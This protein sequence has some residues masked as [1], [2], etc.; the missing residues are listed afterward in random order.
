MVGAEVSRWSVR[1]QDV[2]R[3]SPSLLIFLPNY[4]LVYSVSRCLFCQTQNPFRLEKRL[5]NQ[6]YSS[7]TKTFTN[8]CQTEGLLKRDES[9][10]V[11]LN[12]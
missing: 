7:S 10:N 2:S 1:Q 3:Q 9:K 4:R 6:D 5:S 11:L 8:L 12:F